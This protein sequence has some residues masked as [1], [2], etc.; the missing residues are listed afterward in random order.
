MPNSFWQYILVVILLSCDD[1]GVLPVEMRHV[2][3]PMRTASVMAMG[4]ANRP[5]LK[6]ERR[7]IAG[8]GRY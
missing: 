5:M 8:W 1:K 3:M 7:P 6:R 4:R 2:S